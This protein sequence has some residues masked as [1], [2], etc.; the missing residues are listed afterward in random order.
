MTHQPPSLPERPPRTSVRGANQR[1]RLASAAGLLA[2]H[3]GL[4]TTATVAASLALDVVVSSPVAHARGGSDGGGS[5]GGDDG[6]GDDG[7][8]SGRGGDDGGNSGRGGND[9]GNSGRGGA[10]S[11]DGPD[12]GD[13]SGGRGRGR[14]RDDD[15]VEKGKSRTV[16]DRF[17]ETLKGRGR[18][19]WS[20]NRSGL[21]EVRYADGWTERVE[22]DVYILLDP[23]RQVVVRRPAKPTDLQRLRA[24][25]PR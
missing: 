20:A 17:L 5:D 2:L 13:D 3:L 9:G 18:V 16:V 6:G 21:V 11:D 23:R 19:V 7:G 10:D 24:A 15:E 14:G 25:A 1:R 8:N 12:R 4:V 22:R